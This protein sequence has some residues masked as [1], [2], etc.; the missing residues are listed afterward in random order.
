MEWGAASAA[1]LR[2]GWRQAVWKGARKDMAVVKCKM[3]G[4]DIA[5]GKECSVA[6]CTHCGAKQT[7]P[8]LDSGK[9]LILFSRAARLLRAC[10]FDKAAGVYRDIAEEF[11]TEA[12]ARWGLVLCRYGVT[13]LDSPEGGKAPACHRASFDS[14][15]DDG[16]FEQALE[17][18]DPP[19]RRIYREEAK[20]IE[21]SRKEVLERAAAEPPC[22]ILICCGEEALPLAQSVQDV[23]VGEGC[24]VFSCPGTLDEASSA[25]WEP[26]IFAALYSARVMLVFGTEGGQFSAPWVK[27]QWSRFLDLIAQGEEKVLLPCYRDL[28]ACDMPKEFSGLRAYNMGRPGDWEDLLCQVVEIAGQSPAAAPPAQK[29]A[30]SPEASGPGVSYFLTERATIRRLSGLVCAGANHTAAVRADGSVIAGGYPDDGQCS[31]AGW[32]DAVAVVAGMGHTVALRA[33]GTAVA[34]GKNDF[35]QCNVAPWTDV[36]ALAAGVSHTV[37]LRSDGT[38]SAIG[39]NDHGQ[40]SVAGWK[41]IVAVAADGYRTIGLKA[42]GTV[43]VAGWTSSHY[44]S[45]VLAWR[46]IVGI[47]SG[48]YHTVGLREDGTVTAV[49]SNDIP[50]WRD[51]VAVSTGAGH[52]V[53][54]KADGTVVAVGDNKFGQ[55]EVSDWRDIV[56]VA[57]GAQH[58]V[59][60]RLDGSVVATGNRRSGQCDVADWKLFSDLRGLEEKIRTAEV[61]RQELEQLN[62]ERT[63]LKKE[64]ANLKGLFSGKR[65]KELE[66]QLA[67]L[68]SA[69]EN[70]AAP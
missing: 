2:G 57:A 16:D 46:D 54:L 38:V 27:N 39:K 47:A 70:Y 23:L 33:D 34:A 8:N 24:R 64:L 14:V 58:T 19:A 6:D 56:A 45:R 25:A 30:S 66:E 12:E 43:A 28:N 9:K 63:A 61:R 69:I 21:G 7:V 26:A 29:A 50:D 53:G 37:A 22:D 60:V 65:R 1:F 15:L 59:G 42:D 68:E 3:C 67:E 10:D 49:G 62:Q 44:K 41:D 31:V 5:V 48:A 18:A 51:I 35:G 17:N 4:G 32:R 11:P 13:Y 20:A 36:T 55:C 40:C 52:S